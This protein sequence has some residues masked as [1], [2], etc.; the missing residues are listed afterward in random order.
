MQKQDYEKKHVT[1]Y[2]HTTIQNKLKI[3]YLINKNNDSKYRITLDEI[4]DYK[5]IV[6]LYEKLGNNENFSYEKLILTLKNNPYIFE[7]NKHVEQKKS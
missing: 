4:D 2:L 5:A 1:P 6:Q 7:I 3:K